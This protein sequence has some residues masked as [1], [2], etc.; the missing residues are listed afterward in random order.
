MKHQYKLIVVKNGVQEENIINT[1]KDYEEIHDEIWK[2][3]WSSEWF[4]WGELMCHQPD[5]IRLIE[6]TKDESIGENKAVV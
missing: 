6:L 2:Y 5:F 1:K 4:Y 3:F